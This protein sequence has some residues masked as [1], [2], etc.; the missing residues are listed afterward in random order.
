MSALLV[1][2]LVP[3]AWLGFLRLE[4]AERGAT[5]VLLVWGALITECILY[6]NQN[7]V[8]PGL[9]HPSL[10]GG[11]SFRLF[12][13]LILVAVG[14]RIYTHGLG[15]FRL[16]GLL[17]ASF[18]GWLAVA[19]VIGFAGDNA[20]DKLTFEAKAIIYLSAIF[21]TAT[22]PAREYISVWFLRKLLGA[23]AIVASVLLFTSVAGV[24]ISIGARAPDAVETGAD[25]LVDPLGTLGPDL[26][27][28]L[29][30]LGAIALALALFAPRSSDRIRLAICAAPL[31]ASTLGPD[32]RAAVVGLGVTAIVMIL[33]ALIS[34]RRRVRATPTEAGLAVAA[35]IAF[36]L[37]PTLINTARGESVSAPVLGT[38]L[39]YSFTSRTEQ[40][41]TQDRLNQWSQAKRLVEERP[42]FGWGL[43]KQYQY[44]E[45]GRHEMLQVDI[46]HN[47]GWDLLMRTGIIGF[48]L[49]V[50]A[51][52]V[53]LTRAWSGFMRVVDGRYAALCLGLTAAISGMIA[54][55]M[56]ESIFEKYR[57]AIALALFI[58]MAL[59]VAGAEGEG[60]GPQKV[61]REQEPQPLPA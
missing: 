15:R 50:A 55:G 20:T 60:E 21:L 22:L 53:T 12:D 13:V 46:T 35:I 18:I 54:K 23:S 29:I 59:S 19:A 56:V 16:P 14:A 33:G 26:A 11:F 34:N 51:L 41:T 57:L 17:W 38:D 28:I 45:P 1:A 4:R 47:I 7:T 39:A 61:E 10:G 44:Y 49:F 5:V 48:G 42:I 25:Q 43:G 8:P 52:G 32:Q 3:V 37:V 31:L 2:A 36:G 58:G 6:P 30:G 9:F 40:L 24:S 27:T